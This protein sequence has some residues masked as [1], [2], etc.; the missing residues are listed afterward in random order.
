MRLASRE[1]M[2]SHALAEGTVQ[3]IAS[4][5]YGLPPI[6]VR[7]DPNGVVY[8]AQDDALYV[9]DGYSGAIV[10]V[11]G[12]RQRRIATIDHGGVVATSRIG[13]IALTRGGT[14][15]VARIG[16][17][18]AGAIVRI[19]ADGRS[20]LLPKLAPELW[21]S[22]LAFDPRE[23]VL[24]ST[25]Y[26][27]SPRGPY[28]GSI[29]AIDLVSGEPS[30]VLDGFSRPVGIAKLGA[31]LV[32]TDARQRAVFRV[33][34]KGGRAVHRLQLAADVAR[35]DSVCACGEDSVLVSTYDDE[36]AEGAVRRIWLDGRSRVI[37]NGPWEPRG[38]ATD[39]KRVFVAAHRSGRVLVFGL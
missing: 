29:I 31:M 6:L 11:E 2:S 7:E 27:C 22:G 32:V 28:D 18:R 12:Q 9:A 13:G 3:S 30:T 8:D 10:R 23:G 37:A 15:F 26:R 4:A 17:G 35:P 38:V 33:E 19:D 39:G 1:R 21:R 24:Y 20:E 14:L 16:H 5:E 36:R 25:Q 34:M